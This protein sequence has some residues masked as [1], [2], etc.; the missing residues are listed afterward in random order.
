[1]A[2]RSRNTFICEYGSCGNR[3]AESKWESQGHRCHLHIGAGLDSVS[4]LDPLARSSILFPEVLERQHPEVFS[5]PDHSPSGKASRSSIRLF[6]EVS[7]D[8]TTFGIGNARAVVSTFNRWSLGKD[9]TVPN[10]ARARIRTG[11]TKFYELIAR[12]EHLENCSGVYLVRFKGLSIKPRPNAPVASEARLAKEREMKRQDK[13]ID[14]FKTQH[15]A[16]RTHDAIC[17]RVKRGKHDKRSSYFVVDPMVSGLA[18]ARNP[19]RSVKSDTALSGTPFG[20][21]PWVSSLDSYTNMDF[22]GALGWSE[23]NIIRKGTP[24]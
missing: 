2:A 5:V 8:D 7:D 17:L 18:P 22:N 6:S 16:E 12:S 9:M 13:F 4:T 21:T 1:M 23:F 10:N 14:L 15:F 19:D 11:A 24:Q 20:E 3:V